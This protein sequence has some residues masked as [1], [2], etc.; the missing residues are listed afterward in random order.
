MSHAAYAY[1]VNQY[2]SK[3]GLFQL[4][5]APP[6][7]SDNTPAVGPWSPDG[8][9]LLYRD[10]KDWF[11]RDMTTNPP[12]PA[13]VVARAPVPPDRSPG[14]AQFSWSADSQTITWA[15]GGQLLIGDPTLPQPSY[16]ALAQDLVGYEWAPAGNHLL[17]VETSNAHVV[18]VNAG[19]ESTPRLFD[20]DMFTVWSPDGKYLLSITPDVSGSVN[21]DLTLTDVTGSTLAST[22]V[23]KP[24]IPQPNV[25][26]VRFSADGSFLVFAG[27]QVRPWIDVFYVPLKPSIGAPVLISNG[28]ANTLVNV[29]HVLFLSP[30]G[31]W[32]G[33]SGS[34]FGGPELDFAVEMSGGVPVAQFPLQHED[35]FSYSWLPKKPQELLAFGANNDD[36]LLNLP[37]SNPTFVPV[38][39][40]SQSLSP[41]ADVLLWTSNPGQ[42]S[43]RD[44]DTLA[45]PTI[46]DAK[47]ENSELLWSPDGQ[48][49]SLLDAEAE[50]DAIEL[51]RVAGAVPSPRVAIAAPASPDSSSLWPPVFP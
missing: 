29:A 8:K 46:I 12:G 33:Y 2:P 50:G 7:M 9:K 3:V 6:D 38:D 35:D 13:L 31:H 47:L 5:S 45:P 20:P 40:E 14:L 34:S 41:V 11:V 51:I 10:G 4:S 15:T 39:S 32:I 22:V 37:A 30:D 26:E 48:F 36:E 21:G 27:A 28:L 18:E 42:I 43:L 23:T 1:D 17:Y 19:K 24:T 16:S 49:I 25:T 44:L